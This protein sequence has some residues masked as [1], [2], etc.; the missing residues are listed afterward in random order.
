MDEKVA[1]VAKKIKSIQANGTLVKET[2]AAQAKSIAQQ[3]AE[4]TQLEKAAT[5]FEQEAKVQEEAR[6]V[7]LSQEDL[8]VYSSK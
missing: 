1:H 7:T 6:S 3:E 4:L 5:K 8:T 2:H